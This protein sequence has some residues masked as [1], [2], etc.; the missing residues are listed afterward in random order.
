MDFVGGNSN[1]II[2]PG[3][4]QSCVNIE[5]LDDNT[6]LEGNEVFSLELSTLF[7]PI[8]IDI[9]TAKVTIIDIDSEQTFQHEIEL[10]YYFNSCF[11]SVPIVGLEHTMYIVEENAG[12]VEVCVVFYN[13]SSSC[14]AASPFSVVVVSQA[15]SAGASYDITL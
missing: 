12:S 11:L 6:A 9:S 1:G 7:L 10:Y 8:P 5:V 13:P 14:P 3:A 2:L 4:T 15:G